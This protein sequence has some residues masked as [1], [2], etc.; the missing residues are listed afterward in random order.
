MR[1]YTEVFIS[2]EPGG[3]LRK[4]RVNDRRPGLLQLQPAGLDPAANPGWQ[5]ITDP[6]FDQ[7]APEPAMGG[8]VRDRTPRT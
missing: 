3:A 6:A 4:R 8:L 7:R 2:T 5:S 1:H